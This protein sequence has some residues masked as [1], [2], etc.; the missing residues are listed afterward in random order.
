[1]RP[2]T[3]SGGE[4][5]T[6]TSQTLRVLAKKHDNGDVERHEVVETHVDHLVLEIRDWGL[7]LDITL[8]HQLHLLA[9]LL[10]L[11]YAAGHQRIHMLQITLHTRQTRSKL[12][13]FHDRFRYLHILDIGLTPI[14]QRN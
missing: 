7:L 11:A 6:W 5:N 8:T 4:K 13:I 10:Q 3:S 1:M 2:P 9:H 12:R 14:I